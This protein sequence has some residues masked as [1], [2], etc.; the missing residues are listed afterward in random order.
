MQNNDLIARY[1]YDEF[2]PT[3]FEPWMNFEK[4]PPLGQKAPD[5]SLWTLAGEETCL[6]DVWSQHAYTVVEFGSFT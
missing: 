5:F 2:I 6:S 1:N 4:S 3:K